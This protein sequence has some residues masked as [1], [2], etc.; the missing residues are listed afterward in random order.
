MTS[1]TE[2]GAT[3]GGG[4]GTCPGRT[5]DSPLPPI[6]G[7]GGSTTKLLKLAAPIVALP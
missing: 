7:D 3:N 4:G 6:A 5:G 2:G 1:L